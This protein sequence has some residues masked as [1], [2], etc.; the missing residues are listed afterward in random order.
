M[1]AIES[2]DTAEIF[3]TI[4]DFKFKDAEKLREDDE[5]LEWLNEQFKTAWSIHMDTVIPEVEYNLKKYD[6]KTVEDYFGESDGSWQD[7]KNLFSGAMVP[8]KVRRLVSFMV[9]ENPKPEIDPNMREGY[10]QTVARQF[11]FWPDWVKK[12]IVE[13]GGAQIDEETGDAVFTDPAGFKDWF[14]KLLDN[15]WGSWWKYGNMQ[16][17]K[18]LLAKWGILAPEAYIQLR[19]VN[20]PENPKI[21]AEHIKS[22]NVLKDPIATTPQ[23]RRVFFHIK[24][25]QLS[26]ISIEYDIKKSRLKPSNSFS[27]MMDNITSDTPDDAKWKFKQAIVAQAFFKDTRK[28]KIGTADDFQE[29]S[30][31]LEGRIITFVADQ[32]TQTGIL[33]LD[34]GANIFP[35]FQIQ[36]LILDPTDELHGRS[37]IRDILNIS[38]LANEVMQ[39]GIANLRAMGNG[40]I[41]YE[42]GA[43]VNEEEL[44]NI[45]AEKIPVVNLGGVDFKPPPGA[46]TSEAQQL[47]AFLERAAQQITGVGEVGEGKSPGDIISGKALQILQSAVS[48]L[49]QLSVNAYANCLTRVATLWL[50]MAPFVYTKGVRVRTGATLKE[51]HAMPFNLGDFLD[52]GEIFISPDTIMPRD[53][54]SRKNMI[55]A[56]ADKQSA[57]GGDYIPREYVLKNLD[58]DDLPEL[59][60][61]IEENGGLRQQLQQQQ[62]ALEEIQQQLQEAGKE[63]EKSQA[64]R[65]SAVEKMKGQVVSGQF[66]L[67]EQKR[68]D[69]GMNLRAEFDG[70]IAT[71]NKRIDQ[72]TKIIVEQI[73]Q[74]NK[75]AD[76][77]KD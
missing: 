32:D 4:E 1:S 30:A 50:H 25:M 36:H 52:G 59:M 26:D 74:S 62:Q 48:Q 11:P 17:V 7:N 8:E 38:N 77:D 13:S 65:D 29:V 10:E 55:I 24:P 63:I 61:D 72:Q 21:I 58:F 71:Q 70:I 41:L 31:Y 40:K 23:D 16:V 66:M 27:E 2:G 28:I 56:L 18:Y 12:G 20:F 54:V 15:I 19:I 37:L 9:K 68:K 22:Q 67:E 3:K 35:G 69:E 14:N 44:S 57:D 47:Y 75:P 51:S 34:D 5:F 6:N 49:M 39:Q 46:I 43:L 53:D 64:E 33:I 76:K 73:K 60:K 42:E 45:I